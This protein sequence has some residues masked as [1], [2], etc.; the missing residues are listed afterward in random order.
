MIVIGGT[1]DS[2]L[3][4]PTP[5]DPRHQIYSFDMEAS[6][7]HAKSSGR[8]GAGSE[9]APWN[10]VYHSLFKVDTQNVGVLW[11]DTIESQSF[12]EEVKEAI[13]V[14][15]RRVLRTSIYNMITNTWRTIRIVDMD[16]N[17]QTIYRFGSTVIP[18]FDKHVAMREQVETV[19][20]IKPKADG[21][22][23]LSKLLI[24]GGI[25]LDDFV[26]ET[27]NDSNSAS[28]VTRKDSMPCTV[29]SFTNSSQAPVE[30]AE[31]EEESKESAARKQK[32]KRVPS[33]NIQN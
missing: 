9:P 11:Y 20:K 27:I 4:D 30:E 7:W 10:L 8:L 28:N 29:L 19:K 3:I 17:Y 24:F 32:K 1:T 14:S 31:G 13:A 26:Q 22:I 2:T 18:I 15:T 25:A 12:Q 5:I 6:T 21:P 33:K 16:P 23:P